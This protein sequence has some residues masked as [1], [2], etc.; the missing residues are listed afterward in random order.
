MVPA[1][2]FCGVPATGVAMT[3]G[4]KQVALEPDPAHVLEF[5]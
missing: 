5:I 1:Q 4:E 2:G 3:G